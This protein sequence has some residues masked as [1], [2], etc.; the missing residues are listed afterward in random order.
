[1]FH[2]LQIYLNCCFLETAPLFRLCEPMLATEETSRQNDKQM[3]RRLPVVARA[4]RRDM[5]SVRYS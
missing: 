1:M 2:Y 5:G 4:I 3:S